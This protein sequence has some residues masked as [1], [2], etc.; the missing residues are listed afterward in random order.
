[1]SVPY[2]PIEPSRANLPNLPDSPL[3]IPT[4]PPQ[5]TPGW[6]YAALSVAVVF[7]CVCALVAVNLGR[8]GQDNTTLNGLIM[9][10]TVLGLPTLLN[11]IKGFDNQAAIK[12]QGQEQQKIHLSINSGFRAYAEEIRAAAEAF[13]RKSASD[14]SAAAVTQQFMTEATRAAAVEAA[15]AAA[16]EALKIAFDRIGV[17]AMPPSQAESAAPPANPARPVPVSIV[18]SDPSVEVSVATQ[19]ERELRAGGRPG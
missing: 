10:A 1:V 11:L 18:S 16:S 7:M 3:L 8:P 14:E 6:V 12:F 5:I 9:A 2:Q 4:V 19:E 15:R 17:G 13:G